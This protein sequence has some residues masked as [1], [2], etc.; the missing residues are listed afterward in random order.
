MP[1]SVE[2]EQGVIGSMLIAPREA[3]D[4]AAET[5]DES[6]FY[7]RSHQ[8]LF[9]E[10]LGQWRKGGAI[11]LITFTQRLRDGNLLD[12]V[13]GAAFVTSLFSFVPSPTAVGFYLE[14]VKEKFILR[15]AIA[16]C[17]E[18]VCRSYEDQS[19]VEGMLSDLESKIL[20]IRRGIS[21]AHSTK[22]LVMESVERI[23]ACY[24]RKGAIGGLTTGIIE[25][26]RTTDGLHGSDMIV[27]A[28]RPSMG[29]T[30]LAMNIADH[31]AVELNKPVGVFSLEMSASQLMDRL[32]YSRARVNM[33]KVRAGFLNE[34]DFGRI[35]SA[36]AKIA[37]S[38]LYI[39]DELTPVEILVAKMRRM[40][41]EHGIVLAIVDYLQLLR[42]S[43]KRPKDRQEEV[44]LIS[45][46][47]KGAAKQLDIPVIVA[48]QLNRGPEN[49]PGVIRGRPRLSDLR[50]SGA[51]E[52]DADVVG[53]LFRSEVYA[54]DEDEKAELEGKAELIIA[55]QRSGPTGTIPLTFLKE[56]TR[57]EDRAREYQ[58]QEML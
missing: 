51:I 53:L 46:Q 18:G 41:R 7:I 9:R 32:I 44:S 15:E 13:G 45:S 23:E 1:H 24:E 54:D 11:D 50:E 6:F 25:L 48:A 43:A 2:A 21:K 58:E 4:Q 34:N 26:D 16:V 56:Y 36:G 33:Q 57:F 12:S 20:G 49:R 3:I 5:I 27:I 55:K 8:T 29:K 28:A 22:D 38:P 40:K 35:S 17:T 30:A 37:E 47:L 14:I 52:Q 39:D 10:I 42:S 31:L 19:D